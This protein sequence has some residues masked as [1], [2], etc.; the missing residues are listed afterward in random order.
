MTSWMMLFSSFL[1]LLLGCVLQSQAITVDF[2]NKSLSSIRLAKALCAFWK[3]GQPDMFFWSRFYQISHVDHGLWYD[4]VLFRKRNWRNSWVI[5]RWA[6]AIALRKTSHS[7]WL[8]RSLRIKYLLLVCFLSQLRR[9]DVLTVVNSWWEA[10]AMFGSLVKTSNTLIFSAKFLR[11]HPD[12]LLAI[13]WRQFLQPNG[14]SGY[15]VP[16]WTR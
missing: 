1:A 3:E 9:N 13:Y 6:K 11:L 16:S 5:T 8:L 15:V 14:L 12:Q 2:S 7:Y 10:G 4:D